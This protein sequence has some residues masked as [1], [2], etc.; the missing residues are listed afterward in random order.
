[1]PNVCET[2]SCSSAYRASQA[3]LRLSATATSAHG[4]PGDRPREHAAAQEGP[5]QRALPVDPAAAEPRRLPDRVE[6]RHGRAVLPQ[7]A[8]LEVGLDAAQALAGEDEL[9][10]RDQRPRPG[11]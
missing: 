3:P 8:A 11:V 1:M 4:A 2:G 6:A 5:L 9:A 10:D 7:D